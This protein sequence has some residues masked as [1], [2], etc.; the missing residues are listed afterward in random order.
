M[1]GFEVY[2][3]RPRAVLA[4]QYKKDASNAGVLTQHSL[5]GQVANSEKLELLGMEGDSV[6]VEPG[7][8]IVRVD[9]SFYKYTDDE[10]QAAFEPTVAG[11]RCIFCNFRAPNLDALK[12]HSTSCADHPANKGAASA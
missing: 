5:I 12:S 1:T 6:F 4:A 11:I 2:Q 8:W 7:E 10:F 9:G 3:I